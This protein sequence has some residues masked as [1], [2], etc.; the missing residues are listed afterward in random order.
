MRVMK[1]YLRV[2]ERYTFNQDCLSD[3]QIM[4]II[5]DLGK[6]C[7]TCYTP[8]NVK[9][10]ASWLLQENGAPILFEDPASEDDGE[11]ISYIP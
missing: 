5:E 1:S 9:A 2:L 6:I 11:A 8:E 7:G 3:E 4:C 10:D